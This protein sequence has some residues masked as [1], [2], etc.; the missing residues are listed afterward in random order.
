MSDRQMTKGELIAALSARMGT[1]KKSAAT[2]LDALVGLI[3][4]ELVE[5]GTVV[6]PGIGKISSRERP[7]RMVRHPRT[8]EMIQKESDRMVKVSVSKVLKDHLNA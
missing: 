4:D 6:L 8:G 7:A 5:G 1:D 3:T 2:A